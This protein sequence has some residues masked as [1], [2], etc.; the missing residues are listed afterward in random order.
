MVG[1]LLLLLLLVFTINTAAS[2]NCHLDGSIYLHTGAVLLLNALC[3]ITTV[4]Y[5]AF[6]SSDLEKR[7]SSVQ[8]YYCASMEFRCSRDDE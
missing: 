4:Q 5:D 3:H 2:T 1:G 7:S 6:F 8:D